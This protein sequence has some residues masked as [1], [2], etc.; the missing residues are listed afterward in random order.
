MK[1]CIYF[2]VFFLTG[3]GAKSQVSNDSVKIET[4]SF[5]IKK[6]EKVDSRKKANILVLTNQELNIL[7]KSVASFRKNGNIERININN[8]K[9][10]D[11]DLNFIENIY[12]LKLV[13]GNK[14]LAV[15]SNRINVNGKGV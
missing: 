7:S 13:E 9:V 12:F 3:L 2:L 8:L 11:E 5:N 1:V 10:S 4:V 15:K 6:T 14:V